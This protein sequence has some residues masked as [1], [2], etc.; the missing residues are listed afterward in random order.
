MEH[1]KEEGEAYRTPGK[2]AKNV[3]TGSFF[4]LK[5]SDW[6]L[7]LSPKVEATSKT[8]KP[9]QGKVKEYVL[10]DVDG[11]KGWEEPQERD[12]SG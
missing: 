8:G 10:Q 11:L 1:L 6:R 9:F 2:K 4:N 5:V 7:L 3:K 12:H